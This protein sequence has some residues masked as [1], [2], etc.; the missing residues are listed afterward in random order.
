MR[1]RRRFIGEPKRFTSEPRRARRHRSGAVSAVVEEAAGWAAALEEVE[2]RRLAW[3]EGRETARRR[4]AERTGAS[5]ATLKRL[6]SGPRHWPG[7]MMASAY[8]GLQREYLRLCQRATAAADH[9]EYLREVVRERA[10]LVECET[11]DAG[12]DRASVDRKP[13]GHARLDEAQGAASGEA[14]DAV[15]ARAGRPEI[16]LHRSR[17]NGG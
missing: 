10:A 11:M 15:E 16:D 7:D 8:V 14:P 12:E 6:R 1:E 17:P 13:H 9:Q 4:V 2:R 3:H 5:E